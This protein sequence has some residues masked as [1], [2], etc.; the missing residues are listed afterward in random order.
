MHVANPGK[1]VHSLGTRA[2]N[3]GDRTVET[4]STNFLSCSLKGEVSGITPLHPFASR[5]MY[6]TVGD[7]AS[8]KIL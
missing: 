8:Y 6:F 4:I 1:S 2:S 5:T 3:P 7:L